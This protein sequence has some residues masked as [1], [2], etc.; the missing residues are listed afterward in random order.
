ML[1]ILF[2]FRTTITSY[3]IVGNYLESPCTLYLGLASGSVGKEPT[4][5]CRRH[6]R[7]GFNPWVERSPGG[8]NGKPLQYSCLENSRDRKTWWATVYGV[9]KSR[10]QLSDTHKTIQIHFIPFPPV[11][12]ACKIVVNYNHDT[13]IDRVNMQNII[14]TT[15]SPHVDLL[16]AHSPT[17]H[18]LN[19]VSC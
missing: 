16:N 9:S 10:T 11:V 19:S 18:L 13:D 4:C 6:K 1:I 15:R 3:V 14:L 12:R 8:G 5:Q 7:P 2:I 17:S